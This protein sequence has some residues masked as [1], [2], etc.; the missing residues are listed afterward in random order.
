MVSIDISYGHRLVAERTIYS[1]VVGSRAYGLD[2]P[3][4]D[5]DRRGVFLSPTP[6][7]WGLDKPPTHVDGPGVKQF[8]CEL[9]R[10][11]TLALQANP[12][13]PTRRC[14]TR[15]CPNPPH[16]AR[17]RRRRLTHVPQSWSV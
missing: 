12:T 16:A 9:E 4:S 15:R 10:C 5:I 11:C 6:T 1:S 3:G 13:V 8:S 2:G 14:P 17:R 7:F